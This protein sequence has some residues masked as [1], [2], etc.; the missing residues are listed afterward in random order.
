MGSIADIFTNPPFIPKCLRPRSRKTYLGWVN[1]L[2]TH[3]PDRDLPNL[4]KSEVLD[5][6][7]HLQNERKLRPSTVNQAVCSL[8]DQAPGS[9]FGRE[10]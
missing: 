1:Q 6:L 10:A 5:F 2:A 9:R 7:V 4:D 3:F 8:R